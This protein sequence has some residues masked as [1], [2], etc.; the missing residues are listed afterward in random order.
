MYISWL[1]LQTL[2][3]AGSIYAIVRPHVYALDLLPPDVERFTT[4]LGNTIRG[5]M[6][7]GAL[8]SCMLCLSCLTPGFSVLAMIS[9][10]L[11]PIFKWH[12]PPAL[13]QKLVT[14]L[15][16]PLLIGDVR[17]WQPR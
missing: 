3:V 17:I 11:F 10:S 9:Y 12:T 7:V 13:Q 2:A 4:V 14:G 5:R 8:G 15:L 1:T 6:A 16:V